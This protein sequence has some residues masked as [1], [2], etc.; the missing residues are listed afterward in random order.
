MVALFGKRTYD[1]VYG[2]VFGK[3]GNDLKDGCERFD[4]WG[5]WKV[6]HVDLPTLA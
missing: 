5:L 2:I 6:G 3:T 1:A 4:K